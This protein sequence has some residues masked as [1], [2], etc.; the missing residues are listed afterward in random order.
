MSGG[1]KVATPKD[2][3]RFRLPSVRGGMIRANQTPSGVSDRNRINE[4]PSSLPSSWP[5][6]IR[7]STGPALGINRVDTRLKAGHDDGSEVTRSFCDEPLPTFCR[8]LCPVLGEMSRVDSDAKCNTLSRWNK[9]CGLCPGVL[10][11]MKIKDLQ[12]FFSGYLLTAFVFRRLGLLRFAPESTP[13]YWVSSSH[14]I[15]SDA[16]PSA[17]GDFLGC[18]GN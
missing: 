13:G 17:A 7:P 5:D 2:A 15:P 8:E 4:S 12:T 3:H 1:D 16:P 18:K 14:L 11:T 9:R 10:S 6:L